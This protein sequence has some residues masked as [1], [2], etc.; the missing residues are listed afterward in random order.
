MKGQEDI[1]KDIKRV[2]GSERLY[3]TTHKM[4]KQSNERAVRWDRGMRENRFIRDQWGSEA[5]ISN[6]LSST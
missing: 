2:T 6:N 4:N 3:L 5:Y 1:N